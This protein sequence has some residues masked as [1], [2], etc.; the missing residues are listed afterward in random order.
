MHKILISLFLYGLI[1]G[2]GPCMASCGPILVSYVAGSG[3]NAAKGLWV[4]LLFSLAK[5]FIYLAL[6]VLVFFL[7]NFAAQ[8][9]LG[10]LWRF[11]MAAGGIFICLIGIL[12]AFDKIQGFSCE[13]MAFC[14]NNRAWKFLEKN[15]IAQDKKSVIFMGMFMGLLPC[16]PL[17]AILSYATLVSKAWY[18]SMF[19][20]LSFGIGTILSPLILLVLLSGLITRLLTDKKSNYYRVF[21]FI[22]GLVIIVLGIQLIARSF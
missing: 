5:L 13:S 9:L 22:C 12:I 4:Y 1:F 14:R 20:A 6:S 21:S 18:Q 15:L 19:F 16:A 3:K 7:G 11:V 10:S 17:L 8:R 2:S